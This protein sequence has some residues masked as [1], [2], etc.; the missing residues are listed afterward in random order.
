M[1]IFYS[2]ALAVILSGCSTAQQVNSLPEQTQAMY[3]GA[4]PETVAAA[5][6]HPKLQVPSKI[7]MKNEVLLAP[8]FFQWAL[9]EQ[10]N[11]AF[12]SWWFGGNTVG[13]VQWMVDEMYN[14][15]WSGLKARNN[16]VHAPT[17]IEKAGVAIKTLGDDPRVG[18]AYDRFNKRIAAYPYVSHHE[19]YG[20]KQWHAGTFTQINSKLNPV[21]SMVNVKLHGKWWY[22]GHARLNGEGIVVYDVYTWPTIEVCVEGGQCK[23]VELTEMSPLH[24]N[25]YAP[26]ANAVDAN[27]QKAN[28]KT[29]V[30]TAAKYYGDVILAAIDNM[31]T[32]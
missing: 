24:T 7:A 6:V 31:T 25:L 27:Q 2:L 10:S 9:E 28:N 14:H 26:T 21:K 5:K 13:G 22:K 16:Y 1:R 29:A 17:A 8:I 15:V 4:I 18:D 11:Q 20:F 32:K 19:S 30:M 12:P 3:D 23:K